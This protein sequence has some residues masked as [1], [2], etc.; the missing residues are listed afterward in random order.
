MP[1]LSREAQI[2]QQQLQRKYIDS[3]PAKR[4]RI[5]ERWKQLQSSSWSDAVLAALQADVHRLAG[6]AGSYGLHDLGEAASR[7]EST[8]RSGEASEAWRQTVGRR[9]RALIE[10]L[11]GTPRGEPQ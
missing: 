6:S 1:G 3:L 7:L 11:E 4:S 9:T 10:L 5:E 8:L 2:R